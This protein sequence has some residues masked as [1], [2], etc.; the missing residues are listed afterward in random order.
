MG[1]SPQELRHDIENIRG[2]LGAT[3]DEI[4]DRVSPRQMVRRR[5]RRVGQGFRSAREA[6]MGSAHDVAATTSGRAS[7]A[8]EGAQQTVGT[9]VD[10]ARQ[11]PEVIKRQTEGNPLAAGLVAFGAGLLVASLIPA[12]GPEQQTASKIQEA[13]QPL[14][15]KA[16]EA[17]QQ[18]QSSLQEAARDAADEVKH[19]T[20]GAAEAVKADAQ[21]SATNV[22][23]EAQG[24]AQKLRNR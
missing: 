13:A 16:V 4:G 22:G 10:Q 21:Q 8:I 20:Q 23:Q 24:A 9:V 12:S 19:T 2:D 6:V 1:E 18:L 11:A 3:L 5:T 7:G 14:K 15:D 17:G